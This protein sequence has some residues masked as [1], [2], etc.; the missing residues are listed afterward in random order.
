V[1]VEA[2]L[3]FI[4]LFLVLWSVM[5]LLPWAAVAVI[6]RGRGAAISLPLCLA[7][8]CAFGVAVPVLGARDAAGFLVSLLVAFT[9]SA[10][11][12]GIVMVVARRT[13]PAEDRPGV[14]VPSTRRRPPD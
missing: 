6:S 1:T 5:A 8:G 7:A 9:A 14:V 13:I 10:V 12:A 11:C 3:A 4:L 2:R